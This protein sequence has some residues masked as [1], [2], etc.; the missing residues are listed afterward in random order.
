MAVLEMT[1]EFIPKMLWK[2]NLRRGTG[3]LIAEIGFQ[4]ETMFKKKRKDGKKKKNLEWLYVSE[5]F[6]TAS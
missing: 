5:F 2:K 3:K 4:R 6:C 1:I